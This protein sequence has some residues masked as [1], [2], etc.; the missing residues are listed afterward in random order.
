MGNNFSKFKLTIYII[1]KVW[2]YQM[3]KQ[4][5]LIEEQVI[6]WPKENI[7]AMIYYML[8]RK[9]KIWVTRTT[10]HPMMNSGAPEGYAV[11]TPLVAH[12]VAA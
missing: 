5:L 9:L 3:G 6:Q 7:Q 10:K 4:K 8:H 12:V 1:R 11:S 2:K